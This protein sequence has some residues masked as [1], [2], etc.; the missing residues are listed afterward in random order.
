[1]EIKVAMVEVVVAMANMRDRFDELEQGMEELHDKFEMQVKE[2]YED[3]LSIVNFMEKAQHQENFTFQGRVL[4]TLNNLQALFEETKKSV[5]GTKVDWAI[6]KKAV[7]NGVIVAPIASFTPKV[8]V[9]KAKE[10]DGKRDAKEIDFLCHLE[11]HFSGT[12]HGG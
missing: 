6:G 9:P 11:R 5:E 10:Y 1:M 12:Q 7:T 3:M 8:E 4:E 2:L